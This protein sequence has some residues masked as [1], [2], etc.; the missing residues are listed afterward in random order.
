MITRAQFERFIRSDW[1]RIR[2]AV[3]DVT[4]RSGLSPQDIHAVVRTGGSS[5][6]PVFLDMLAD[7]FGADKL[8][9]EDLFTGVTAGLGITAWEHDQALA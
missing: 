2:Q 1:R 6:I 9:T 4:E 3:I 7:L 5:S 8:V